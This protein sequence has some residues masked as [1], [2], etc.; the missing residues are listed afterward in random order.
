MLVSCTTTSSLLVFS[1]LTPDG[2]SG[3]PTTRRQGRAATPRF[4]KHILVVLVFLKS[5]SGGYA[6]KVNVAGDMC[7]FSLIVWTGR[8][9]PQHCL[10]GSQ[11]VGEGKYV[12]DYDVT[13]A[14]KMLKMAV[15][16]FQVAEFNPGWSQMFTQLVGNCMWL[17]WITVGKADFANTRQGLI[18]RG[19]EWNWYIIYDVKS[20]EFKY[21]W[22]KFSGTCLKCTISNSR[23]DFLMSRV[24]DIRFVFQGS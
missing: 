5:I 12:P 23:C 18:F 22:I 9:K 16:T 1:S 20:P 6:S 2:R 21:C 24:F 19:I 3:G 11:D 10:L 4:Q 14:G 15:P 17:L 13:L 7:T 8:G